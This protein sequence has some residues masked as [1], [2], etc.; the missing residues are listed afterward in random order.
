MNATSDG[1]ARQRAI[2][3]SLRLNLPKPDPHITWLWNGNQPYT[4]VNGPTWYATTPATYTNRISYAKAGNTWVQV[5]ATPTG[6]SL[7]ANNEPEHWCPGP[8]QTPTHITTLT[9]QGTRPLWHN[10]PDGCSTRFTTTSP[11][12]P[13][14]PVTGTM[15]TR[16][17]ITYTANNNTTGTL[18]DMYTQT[19]T[20]AFAIT[21]AQTLITK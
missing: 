7:A 9:N 17:A 20:T 16:W 2:Q 5:T 11:G 15:R 21:E 14:Q 19:P 4:L 8:G 6:L 3:A 1:G 18:P 13:D 12:L 10:S